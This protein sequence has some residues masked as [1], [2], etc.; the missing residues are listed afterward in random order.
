MQL[1]HRESGV[2]NLGQVKGSARCP[3]HRDACRP[4][5]GK[6]IKG[7]VNRG[8]TFFPPDS[9]ILTFPSR[10]SLSKLIYL[11][12]KHHPFLCSD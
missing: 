9:F 1:Y 3:V 4:C 8:S 12:R 10:V 7:G 11:A 5:A 6:G 2:K